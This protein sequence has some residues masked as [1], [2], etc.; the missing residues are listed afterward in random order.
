MWVS[1]GNG[2]DPFFPCENFTD[3]SYFRLTVEIVFVRKIYWHCQNF[4]R[5]TPSHSGDI[6]NCRSGRMSMY[7]HSFMD[8]GLSEERASC[9]S[10][11]LMKWIRIFHGRIFWVEVFKGKFSRGRS[12]GWKYIQWE[13]SRVSGGYSK[14]TSK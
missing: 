2:R 9:N 12:V 1:W 6:K 14:N 7:A 4:K 5:K 10:L 3:A 13:F 11:E 8:K